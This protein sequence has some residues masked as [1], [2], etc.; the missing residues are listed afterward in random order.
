MDK[1]VFN[2][3]LQGKLRQDESLTFWRHFNLYLQFVRI[4]HLVEVDVFTTE[5]KLT[6]HGRLFLIAN[7]VP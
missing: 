5:R 1:V 2:Q 6:L 4:T 7:I 3:W